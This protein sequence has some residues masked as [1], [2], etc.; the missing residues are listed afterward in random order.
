MREELLKLSNQLENVTA[1]LAEIVKKETLQEEISFT[2][3][4]LKELLNSLHD[5]VVDQ[6]TSN[7]V[8]HDLIDVSLD[9]DYDHRVT[10]VE[11]YL[12]RD[13]FD[14]DVEE[15]LLNALIQKNKSKELERIENT[16]NEKTENTNV[17]TSDTAN[18]LQ[19]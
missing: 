7:D 2:R 8:C 19:C 5:Y 18:Q 3:S 17:N 15:F 6:V 1:T 16:A 12:S 14:F 11:A 10:I 13:L 4:E 9:M